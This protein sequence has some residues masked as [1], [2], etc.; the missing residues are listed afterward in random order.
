MLAEWPAGTLES[1]FAYYRLE[2]WGDDWER[3]SIETVEVIN[4]VQAL[5]FGFSG[6][7]G[8]PPKP[9]PSD[10]LVPY[11]EHRDEELAGAL[12]AVSALKEMSGL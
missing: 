4:A 9:I 3:T 8:E 7:K 10:A 5:A 1:W 2:P 11:R 12:Q 6:G